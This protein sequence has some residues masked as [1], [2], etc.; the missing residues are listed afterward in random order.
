[1]R[2]DVMPVVPDAEVGEAWAF[3]AE[4][5]DELRYLAVNRH[6]MYRPEFDAL[7]ADERIDKY[8]ARGADGSLIGMGAMTTDLHAVPLISADYFRHHFPEHYAGNRL[9]YVVFVGAR[10][11]D[12]GRGVFL[13]LLREMYRP[14]GEAHGRVFVDVCTYN[15]E[16]HQLPKMIGL[17]LTRVTG[18]AVPTRLDSQ[19]FWMY[20]FPRGE[21]DDSPAAS[22]TRAGTSASTRRR[23]PPPAPPA[24]ASAAAMPA[25][26]QCA[27]NSA[28]GTAGPHSQPWPFVTP[29]A[30]SASRCSRVSTP[31]AITLRFSA[32]LIATTALTI[33]SSSA[34]VPRP[35]T[36]DLSIFT[37][38]TGNL[39]R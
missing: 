26:C 7:M 13:T 15:E 4:T 5:F 10:Q 8:L 38:V 36:N 30:A 9:F 35:V 39:R 21:H 3:Y 29:T 12:P 19:S 1:M 18:R 16:A 33:S 6:L 11:G 25:A 28:G 20:E 27:A 24:P 17:I 2:V 14:I 37:P 31:S 22:R 34:L 32:W 23:A